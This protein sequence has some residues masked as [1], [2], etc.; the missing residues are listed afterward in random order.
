MVRIRIDFMHSLKTYFPG[1]IRT[2]RK[3]GH[4]SLV[5]KQNDKRTQEE[6]H[7]SEHDIP[8]END[9][10]Q[11]DLEIDVVDDTAE[12]NRLTGKPVVGDVLLS[13]V[14]VC[15]PYHTLSQYM[16]RVKLTPGNMKR[17]KASKQCLEIF[18][19]AKQGGVDEAKKLVNLIKRVADSDWV[20]AMSGDVKI[21]APGAGK[22]EKKHKA[23]KK[24]KSQ[25]K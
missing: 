8:P 25:K 1:I 23:Q 17:G 16:Y 5:L 4:D 9:P 11:I 12:L 3:Y 18:T 15:A 14:P 7:E 10:D 2:I 6:K 20:N 13:A 22:I 24:K 21:S 19:R